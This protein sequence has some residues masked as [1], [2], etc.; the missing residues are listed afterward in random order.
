MVF[1]DSLV[2]NQ[3]LSTI[4]FARNGLNEDLCA[5]ILQRLYFNEQLKC[6]DFNGNPITISNFRDEIVKKYFSSRGNAF[7]IIYD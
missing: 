2:N 4:G 5:A 7:K 6:I 3:T 1:S